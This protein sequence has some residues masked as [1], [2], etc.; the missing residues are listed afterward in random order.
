MTHNLRLTVIPPRNGCSSECQNQQ[1]HSTLCPTHDSRIIG[2]HYQPPRFRPAHF[3]GVVLV[4]VGLIA[5]EWVLK[6]LFSSDGIL[7]FESRIQ[8]WFFDTACV[9][10]GIALAWYS[11]WAPPTAK[12]VRHS[13]R[14]YPN[15]TLLILGLVS[16]LA[17]WFSAEILFYFVNHRRMGRVV[18]E[19]RVEGI[20]AREGVMRG[21][22]R[23]VLLGHKP[24]PNVRIFSKMTVKGRP[25]FEFTC[26]TDAQSRRVTPGQRLV[27]IDKFI[28]FFGCSFTFGEGVQDNETLPYFVGQ[29]ASRYRPYNYGVNGYGPQ[30]M[31]A[32][33]QQEEIRRE[34][35]QPGGV[36][37]YTF[38]DD[39]MSRM[40]GSQRV[41]AMNWGRYMPYYGLDSNGNLERRG[42]FLSGRPGLTLLFRL[43]GKS[44]VARYFRIG[45]R[46][47]IGDDDFSLIAKIFAES[48]NAF[49]RIFNSEKFFVL[50]YPGPIQLAKATHPLLAEE[51]SAVLRLLHLV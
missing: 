51:R 22:Q 33:L 46:H 6:K 23:D 11:H 44:E 28:L 9:L 25:I 16:T 8:I 21:Y 13:V 50:I 40:I 4:C 26:S 29:L 27:D 15:T 37:I 32:K 3:V 49:S 24:L 48:R 43:L 36:S 45:E 10:L 18:F 39:H 47:T 17:F 20:A 35:K 14:N 12:A 30:Q 19:Q 2:L 31:V 38:I 34:I 7:E 1:V 42:N 5:N 41:I